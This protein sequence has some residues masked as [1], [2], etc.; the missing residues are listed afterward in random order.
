MPTAADVPDLV[1][2]FRAAGL[3]LDLTLV[4]DLGTLPPATGLALYRVVQESLTNVV[5]HAPATSAWVE[6]ERDA[7]GVRLRV[8]NALPPGAAPSPNGGLG[9]PG[10]RERIG[11]LGGTFDASTDQGRW[12]VAAD[13]PEVAVS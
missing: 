12:V 9:V 6:L 1:E 2:E 13:V 10:M 4:G 7:G 11:L 5:K 8:S 3:D